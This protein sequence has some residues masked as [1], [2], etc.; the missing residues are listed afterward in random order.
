MYLLTYEHTPSSSEV[1][2]GSNNSRKHLQFIFTDYIPK[3][4]LLG[5]IKQEAQFYKPKS[6][7]IIPFIFD[8]WI[9]AVGAMTLCCPV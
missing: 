1:V 3:G 7:I 5:R 9:W 6:H 8:L 2:V 4:L